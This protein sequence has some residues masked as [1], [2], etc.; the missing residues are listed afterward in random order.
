L[1]PD[2]NVKISKRRVYGIIVLTTLTGGCGYVGTAYWGWLR[3][4]LE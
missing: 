3:K 4:W 2:V 1:D